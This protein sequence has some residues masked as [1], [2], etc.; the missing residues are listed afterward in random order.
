MLDDMARSATFNI[1]DIEIEVRDDTTL[2]TIT[3]VLSE[4]DDLE[5]HG[6]PI[7]AFPRQLLHDESISELLS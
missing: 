1:P 6:F 5:A 4:H 7:S 3:L 2:T